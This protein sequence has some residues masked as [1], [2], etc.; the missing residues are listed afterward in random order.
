VQ[1]AVSPDER[2]D[3][4][5]IEINPRVSR[6][7]ALA[8]K[9]TGYPIAKI[10]GKIALGY[11][12]DE[13]Q[14]PITKVSNACFEPALD[15]IVTK[16]PKWPFDQ[17]N[18]TNKTLGSSMKAIGE[19]MAI[20]KNFETSFLKALRSLE[21]KNFYLFDKESDQASTK[22]LLERLEDP[23]EKRVYQIAQLLRRD[24]SL[25]KIQEIT[26]IDFWFLEKIQNIL[27]IEKDLAINFNE[28]LLHKAKNYGFSN[29]IISMISKKD[30]KEIEDLTSSSSYLMIDSCSGEFECSTPYLYSSYYPEQYIELPKS[31]KESV[32]ILGSGPIRIGQGVEFDYS[33]VHAIKATQEANFE[34][35]VLNCNPET[36]STDFSTA[37]RLYFEP[38]FIDDVLEVIKHEK[39]MGVIC[40]FAGQTGLNLIEKLAEAGVNILGTSKESIDLCE[41]REKFEAFLRSIDVRTP[42]GFSTKNKEDAKSIAKELGYPLMIRPSYVTGGKDMAIVHDLEKLEKYLV[43]IFDKSVDEIFIDEYIVGK[44]FEVDAAS[45]GENIFIPGIMEHLD[46]SGIHSGDSFAVYPPQSLNEAQIKEIEI[47]ATKIAQSLNIKGLIN[48]QLI[49]RAGE[50]FVIEANPRASRTVPFISKATD[51]KLANIATRAVLGQKIHSAESTESSKVFIKSPVFSFQKLKGADSSLGPAMKSTGEA[52]GIGTNFKE[53]LRKS[54]LASGIDIPEYGDV[55]LTISDMYKEESID[56]AKNLYELGFNIFATHGTANFL[57]KKNIHCTTIDKGTGPGSLIEMVKRGGVS[58]IVNGISGSESNISDGHLMRR[59]AIDS[60]TICLTSLDTARSLISVIKE[61]AQQVVSL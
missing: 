38:L 26:R 47:I 39:P 9:A 57:E 24:V 7:S 33:T 28:S 22:E 50:F 23:T 58:I 53:A 36:V 35:I 17:I 52:I 1:F 41:D 20:G 54:F 25:K 37:D 11:S 60:Q 10:A 49:Q 46:R 14:N 31:S 2:E 29:S 21:D 27:E 12:L 59:A 18:F 40:Q 56:I 48:I 4:V 45:D 61:S 13:L 3:I 6:S 55:I 51:T 30:I 32:L 42:K 16:I 15:Y 44:E 8:S 5:A 43:D 34:A 19:V